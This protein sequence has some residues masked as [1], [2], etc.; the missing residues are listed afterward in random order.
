MLLQLRLVSDFY[1]VFNVLKPSM[2][3]FYHQCQIATVDMCTEM[4]MAVKA[5]QVQTFLLLVSSQIN[6]CRTWD[7]KETP[8][9][10]L[11]GCL[12]HISQ[13]PTTH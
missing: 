10:I 2:K 12:V 5:D 4:H 11:S 7:S 3:T 1:V 13:A 8:S 6:F 9:K